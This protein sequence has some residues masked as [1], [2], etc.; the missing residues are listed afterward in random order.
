MSEIGTFPFGQPIQKVEQKDRNPKRV[1]FLGV[2]ASAVHARWIG[3][4]GKSV[5][6]A[7]GVASEPEIFWKG[8]GDEEIISR[9][10][11]PEKAGKLVPAAKNLNGPSGQTLDDQYLTPM[12]L[13]RADV[14]L[15]DLVPHSCMNNGQRDAL[16]ARYIKNA[17]D[18]GLPD[19]HWPKLPNVLATP[20]RRAEMQAEIHEA[21]PD[22][23]VALGDL[24]LK[25]FFSHFG[26]RAT[27]AAYS[28]GAEGGYGRLHEIRIG[29]RQLR[30]LPLAHPRQA[31][32]LGSHS[33]SWALNHDR[34]VA[35]E[36]PGI[37]D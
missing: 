25:W 10:T 6:K 17:R 8:E 35:E 4:D 30:L 3:S 18:W 16:E 23:V 33:G 15:C 26:S 31:G 36:A 2:Y 9:I 1:F 11:L 21:Q 29:E 12:G 13:T 34:W 28:E 37:L 14:W 7:V 19:F 32:R 24:P 22:V 20:E 5:I 27:L